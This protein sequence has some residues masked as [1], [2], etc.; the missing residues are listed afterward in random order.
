METTLSENTVNDT[1]KEKTLLVA[2]KKE[3]NV[4]VASRIDAKGKLE[5]VPPSKANQ[6]RFVTVDKNGDL[7]S[8]FYSNFMKHMPNEARFSL[9][10]VTRDAAV[11]L[12]G[13]VGALLEKAKELAPLSE[14]RLHSPFNQDKLNKN[15]METTEKNQETAEYRY[16]PDQV[17]WKA[18]ASMGIDRDRLEKMNLMEPLLKGFKT[19]EL[20]PLTLTM[21]NTVTRLDARL[22]LQTNDSGQVVLAMH[23]IR[24]EPS[25]NYPFFGHEFT[26]EDK[27]NLRN[28]GNMGRVVDL[29]NQKSGE[30][31]PSLISVDKK[32][33]ELVACRQE[34]VKIPDE[35]KG[36]TLTVQ[37]KDHLSEGKPVFLE[38]MISKKGEPFDATVQF[39]ADKRYVEF[40][41]DRTGQSQQQSAQ[42]EVPRTVRGKELDDAQYEKYKEGQT[43]YLTGLLD[44]QGKEYKGYVTLDKETGKP[45]FSFDNPANAKEKAVPAEEHKTQT[46]VNS[47]GKT[48]EATKHVKEAL[49]EGQS[50]PDSRAQQQ[51]QIKPEPAKSKGRKM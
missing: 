12:A 49:K 18:L 27:D 1:D 31:V 3:R 38:G 44:K 36:I 21:G 26:Q 45:S 37:Q 2:D 29:Y 15:T 23:G 30:N 41:F 24:K 33:N 34:W 50:A 28:S 32:T 51:E 5:T 22:S 47:E 4:T 6:G 14:I 48:N 42:Q 7:F 13:Y 25:L 35:I 9:F 40:L 16:A 39:N 43:I 10:L 17:D 46:A 19:N 8:N 20:V 11:E